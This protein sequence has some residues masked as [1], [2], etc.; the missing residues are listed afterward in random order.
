MPAT[1]RET[2]ASIATAPALASP[3]SSGRWWHLLQHGLLLPC[4]G[5]SAFAL[6]A[7]AFA[8]E[9]AHMRASGEES[10]LFAGGR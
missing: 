9:S 2:K 4:L 1:K 10:H 6:W 7:V 3:P 8:L 5:L